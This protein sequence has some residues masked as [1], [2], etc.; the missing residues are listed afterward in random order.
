MTTLATLLVLCGIGS[1]AYFYQKPKKNKRSLKFFL[2]VALL[3]SGYGLGI[4]SDPLPPSPQ[5]KEVVKTIVNDQPKKQAQRLEDKN[6][7]LEEEI[8]QKQHELATN[9]A[10]L[11]SLTNTQTNQANASTSLTTLN[12]PTPDLS[13][14]AY[15]GQEVIAINNNE[16]GFSAADLDTS[17]G[18][19]QHYG[20]LDTLNRVTTADALLNKNLMPTQPRERLYINPTG[21]HNKKI[22]SGWLYNRSHLI[23]F[24]LTGQ[25]NNIKNLMTG[26]RQLND[27]G[28]V[29]YENHIAQYLKQNPNNYVRYSVRPI[30]AGSELLARGVQLRAQSVNSSAVEFNV[31]IFNVQPGVTLNYNDGTSQVG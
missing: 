27:P 28:M 20:D 17:K 19:W 8:K 16:P 5:P 11:E 14:L 3:T 6:E 10:T 18:A 12:N 2:V 29:D 26:T 31:Y 23:G 1:A 25:N 24:Q 22:S 21:W 13:T 15:S 4:S 7:Q 30:F 9:Q